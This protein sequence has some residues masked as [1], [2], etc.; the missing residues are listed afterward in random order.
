MKEW[1]EYVQEYWPW[2]IQ[3]HTW[4]LKNKFV[5]TKTKT[6]DFL[7]NVVCVCQGKILLSKMH[8]F[9][10]QKGNTSTIW[11]SRNQ[12]TRLHVS[13]T[14]FAYGNKFAPVHCTVLTLDPTTQQLKK[15]AEYILCMAKTS[16]KWFGTDPAVVRAN[17]W[18]LPEISM[19]WGIPAHFAHMKSES[20]ASFHTCFLI[21]SNETVV[22]L[23]T[24][25]TF[26]VFFF[27]KYN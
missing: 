4:F 21:C 11:T 22:C 5:A 14:T 23:K 7:I 15:E 3:M 18:L 17:W 25:L 19:L 26:T 16:L 1:Q 27:H 20:N 6:T 8:W 9:E 13:V 12:R 24:G 2:T 10:G